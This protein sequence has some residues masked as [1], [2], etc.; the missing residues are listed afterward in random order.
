MADRPD[1]FNL[2][3]LADVASREPYLPLAPAASYRAS[4]TSTAYT[5]AS[6]SSSWNPVNYASATGWNPFAFPS[7]AYAASDPDE[8]EDDDDIP[9]SFRPTT[10]GWT[11]ASSY[12]PATGWPRSYTTYAGTA[13]IDVYQ[14]AWDDVNTP[15]SVPQLPRT[16]WRC[17]PCGTK[18]VTRFEAENHPCPGS[19][20]LER[21]C[22]D[23]S[24]RDEGQSADEVERPVKR[25]RITE[26]KSTATRKTTTTRKSKAQPKQK[27]PV[28]ENNA[29]GTAGTKG[30]AKAEA[31]TPLPAPL[32]VTRSRTRAAKDT[33]QATQ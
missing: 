21:R 8:T 13:D 26:T 4:T 30:K 18:F 31:E 5:S 23:D 25:R 15:I 24:V 33:A 19:E 14:A 1:D 29:A 10:S 12:A 16:W 3:M 7:A 20:S 2:W 27:A 6:M 32:R 22:G 28:K 9:S 17:R 11:S